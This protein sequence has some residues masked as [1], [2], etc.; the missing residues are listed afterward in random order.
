MPISPRPNDGT[1]PASEQPT[2]PP[3]LI[4]LNRW[5]RMAGIAPVTA[6]RYR[7]RG[8]LKTLNICGRIYVTS[9]ALAEFLRRA[10]AGEFAVASSIGRQ[11]KPVQPLKGL[12]GDPPF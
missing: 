9:T 12:K 4:A 10:E 3:T 5:C 7:R 2:S 8:W 1:L 11:H 6:W